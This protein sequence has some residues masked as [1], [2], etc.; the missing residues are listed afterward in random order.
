LEA[1]QKVD[2][3]KSHLARLG[4]KNKKIFTEVTEKTFLAI[5]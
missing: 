5:V 4:G 2:E 3:K 1:I